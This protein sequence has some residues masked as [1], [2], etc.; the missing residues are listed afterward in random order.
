MV[1]RARVWIGWLILFLLDECHSLV[2]HTWL[3]VIADSGV[4]EKL[5]SVLLLFL[6]RCIQ[7]VNGSL[8]P[9]PT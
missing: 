2:Q 4:I 3:T 6:L 5:L 9:N 1:Y 7:F 8:F